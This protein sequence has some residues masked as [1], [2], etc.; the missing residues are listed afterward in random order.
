VLVDGSR[1]VLSGIQTDESVDLNDLPTAFVDRVEVLK[2]GTQLRY[3]PDAV[4]GAVNV[5]LKDQIEGVRL[6]IFG[7]AAGLPDGGTADISLVGGHSFTNGHAAFGLAFYQRDPVLQSS[8]A[9][10]ADPISFAI[11][12]PSGDQILSGS[13]A[14]P[15]GHAV[16]SGI[17]ARA[18]GGG[19]T[20][21]YDPAADSYDIA[22]N[23][24]LQGGCRVAANGGGRPIRAK[25]YAK[26]RL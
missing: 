18:L 12:T 17:N 22:P 11:A 3:G 21:P 6:E 8:R 16:G 20:A 4:A 1:F 23:H 9:W 5:V 15:G 24:D 2:D 7:A 14:T 25:T 10:A 19:Q 26:E 13:P